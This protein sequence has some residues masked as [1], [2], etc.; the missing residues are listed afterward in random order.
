M[1][2]LAQKGSLYATRPTLFTYASDRQSLL[3]MAGEVAAVLGAG[4][5]RIDI[6]NRFAL[7]DAA[8]AHRAL[9]RRETSGAT[10]LIP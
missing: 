3:A 2:L 8:D 9:E 6:H 10:V 1:A 4:T 7:K 5:V